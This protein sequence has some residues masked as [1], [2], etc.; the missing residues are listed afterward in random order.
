[1][2]RIILFLLTNLSVV[3]MFGIIL[4]ITGI[5]A[6]S[7]K[8]LMILAGIVGF[9]GSITSLLLS[10]WAALRSTNA[11]IINY[12]RNNVEKWIMQSVQFQSQQLGI[13]IPTIAIYPSN[14]VN[15]F[16]TGYSQNNALIGLSTS[17]LRKMNK[18]N[19]QAVIAHEFSHIVNGD[20]V[21]LTLIQGVINTFVFFISSMIAKL[22][23]HILSKH[24]IFDFLKSYHVLIHYTISMTLQSIFGMLASVIVLT[25]SRYREFRADAD[26][27]KRIGWHNMINLLENFRNLTEP[28]TKNNMTTYCI[29][30]KT[31]SFMNLFDS[32][33]PLKDRI[34]A[35]L[36][37]SYK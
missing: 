12:P 17:L 3:C 24:K 22:V 8:S 16:A 23:I 31:Q 30:G 21:T 18:K 19:I 14:T 29:R 37:Q 34:E 7:V 15:A 25:F 27:A 28:K 13:Q 36:K 35:L 32:H 20:M 5:K 2:I 11:K 33:P 9:S 6:H 26:A 1:M 10:K 4:F